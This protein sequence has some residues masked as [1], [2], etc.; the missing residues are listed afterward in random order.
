MA[1][2]CSAYCEACDSWGTVVED[3]PR[4]KME[5]FEHI[6]NNDDGTADYLCGECKAPITSEWDEE[7]TEDLEE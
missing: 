5:G 3:Q 7:E 6:S 1:K 2:E 4:W